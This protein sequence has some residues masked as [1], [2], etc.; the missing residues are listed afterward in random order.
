MLGEIREVNEVLFRLRAHENRSMKANRSS[1]ARAGWYDPAA[2]RKSFVLPSW[3]RMVWELLKAVQRSPL[4]PTEKVR[5]MLTVPGTHYWRRVRNWG[6]RLK[7]QSM[8]C[9]NQRRNRL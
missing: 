8:S 2:A 4:D 1:R 6:G 3:E 5:C 9:I 7:M